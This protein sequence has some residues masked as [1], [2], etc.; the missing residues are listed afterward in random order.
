MRETKADDKASAAIKLECRGPLRIFKH[1]D[2][3]TKG[4]PDTSVNW[5]GH[6]SWLEYKMLTGHE[7]VHNELHGL[8]L[9]ELIRLENAMFRAWVVAYRNATRTLEACLDIYRPTALLHG[10]QP[11]AKEPSNYE[12]LL[13]NLRDHGVARFPGFNHGAVAQLIKQTH[14]GY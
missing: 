13:I 7:N 1:N 4:M 8:Q 10:A 2:R 6:T 3:G 5:N 11:I 14:T 9:I 12:N